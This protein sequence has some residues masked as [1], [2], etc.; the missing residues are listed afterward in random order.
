MRE[1]D[2][3]INLTRKLGISISDEGTYDEQE[4]KYFIIKWKYKGQTFTHKFPGSTNTTTMNYQYYQM[5]KNLRAIGL[6]PPWE[7]NVTCSSRQHEVLEEIWKY[8]GTDDEGGT[9][10]GGELGKS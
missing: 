5:R 1:I 4:S 2:T 10:Y 6:T 8:L 3:L 7:N 9:P